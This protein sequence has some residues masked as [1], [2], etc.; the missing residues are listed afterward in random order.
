M[1][2]A[3]TLSRG[4]TIA[5]PAAWLATVVRNAIVTRLRTAKARA[6]RGR[7]EAVLFAKETRTGIEPTPNGGSVADA[8]WR[9]PEAL[10][11][12]LVLRLWGGLTLEEVA[13]VTGCSTATAFRNHQRALEAMKRD[14]CEDPAALRRSGE[15]QR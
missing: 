3:E 9:L 12:T 8:L 11:E 14:L 4:Q 7:D 5:S 10:R 15:A 13:S 1:K 6:Q 2:L